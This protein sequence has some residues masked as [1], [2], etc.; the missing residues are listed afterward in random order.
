MA[1]IG[2][3]KYTNVFP[4]IWEKILFVAVPA[5]WG[6]GSGALYAAVNGEF[7]LYT[8]LITTA[9]YCSLIIIDPHGKSICFS[10]NPI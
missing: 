5:L 6:L 2:G 7:V 3:F 1:S 8:G 9:V 10:E 4:A